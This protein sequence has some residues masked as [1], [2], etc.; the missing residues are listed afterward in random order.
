[1]KLTW[2]KEED[3]KRGEDRNRED[4]RSEERRREEK[5]REEEIRVKNQEEGGQLQQEKLKELSSD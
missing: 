2:A 4:R 1:M 3:K 5:G